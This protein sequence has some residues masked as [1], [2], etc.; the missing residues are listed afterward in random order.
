MFKKLTILLVL[1]AAITSGC[2][3]KTTYTS[4]DG[5]VT[6][7]NKGGQVTIESKTKDGNATITANDKGIPLPDNFPKDVPIYKGAVVKVASTQGKSMMV[8]MS[9]SAS[10]ADLLKF[11]QDQL[12]DQG[13]EI[14]ST[15]NMGE[16]SMISAKKASRQCTALVMKQEK[17]SLV[18]LTVVQEGS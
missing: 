17:D 8:H 2:G 7:D 12:K 5:E 13:W 15:M 4:K 1:V 11:Y 18:Q 10:A 6:V 9:V 16:G 14:Q 3:K